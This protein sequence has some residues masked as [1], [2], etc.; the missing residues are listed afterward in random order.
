MTA[1]EMAISGEVRWQT[2]AS[3]YL[4]TGQYWWSLSP[5]YFVDYN[6]SGVWDFNPSGSLNYFYVTNSF[7]VRP[8]VSLRPDCVVTDGDGSSDTPY[9]IE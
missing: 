7:G 5:G 9:I 3:I 4:I 2:N 1:D 8:V 6:G